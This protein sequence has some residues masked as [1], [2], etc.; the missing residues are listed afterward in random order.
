MGIEF[1]RA[2]PSLASAPIIEA[3][4]SVREAVQTDRATRRLD[5]QSSSPE[6][7]DRCPGQL[8]AR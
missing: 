7:H 6:H 1:A 3:A 8:P 2:A 4:E 5:A